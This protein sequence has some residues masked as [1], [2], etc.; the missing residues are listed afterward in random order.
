MSFTPLPRFLASPQAV[1]LS[2][3]QRINLAVDM[4]RNLYLDHKLG[5][6]HNKLLTE[7]FVISNENQHKP[8]AYLFLDDKR[9]TWADSNE[10]AA[11]AASNVAAL[12]NFICQPLRKNPSAAPQSFFEPI[13]PCSL[14]QTNNQAAAQL[15][16]LINT[17][18]GEPHHPSAL[19]LY[20][21]ALFIKHEL[22]DFNARCFDKNT[23]EKMLETLKD[24]QPDWK[25]FA[26][27]IQQTHNAVTSERP[28][29]LL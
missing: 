2:Q 27:I 29:L 1:L 12:I 9:V 6:A 26:V 22:T 21:T 13:K 4:C 10:F 14:L 23:L 17:T 16:A 3:A 28:T 20:A 7:H 24:E 11:L 8:K 25:T 15:K 5:M 18:Q 19:E